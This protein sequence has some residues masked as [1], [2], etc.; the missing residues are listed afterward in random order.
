M[1][2]AAEQTSLSS[3]GPTLGSEHSQFSEHRDPA[4]CGSCHLHPA[5]GRNRTWTKALPF[6]LYRF[7][8]AS[9][10]GAGSES[11]FPGRGA[12]GSWDLP[13]PCFVGDTCM[14]SLD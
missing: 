9:L 2:P 13:L 4:V 3:E 11:G 8:S 10:T 5:P 12:A 7:L 1:A 14:L 6:L